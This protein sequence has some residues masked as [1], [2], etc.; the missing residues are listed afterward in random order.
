MGDSTFLHIHPLQQ[1]TTFP[2]V[3][4]ASLQIMLD[5]SLVSLDL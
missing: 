2:S 1:D 3:A 5:E 4:T